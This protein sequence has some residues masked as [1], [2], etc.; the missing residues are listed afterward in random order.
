ML[1]SAPCG[2][3]CLT[4][5]TYVVLPAP[6]LLQLL[7]LAVASTCCCCSL[8]CPL[9]VVPCGGTVVLAVAPADVMYSCSTDFLSD[10][11]CCCCRLLLYAASVVVIIFGAS[12]C[13]V[14][15]MSPTAPLPYCYSCH[16]SCAPVLF[17]LLPMLLLKESQGYKIEILVCNKYNTDSTE[18][19]AHGSLS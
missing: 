11:C 3:G 1:P 9:I 14:T 19:Q 4:C 8:L 16:Y 7:L 17:L 18:F 13:Y 5:C 15:H 10:I 2:C 6:P 12:T